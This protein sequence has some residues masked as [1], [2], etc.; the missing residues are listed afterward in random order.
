MAISAIRVKY[1]NKQKE[2]TQVKQWGI[3]NRIE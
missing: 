3:N 2:R 1:K